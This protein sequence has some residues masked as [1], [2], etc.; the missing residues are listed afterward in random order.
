MIQDILPL[1]Q[2]DIK[3]LISELEKFKSNKELWTT[4]GDVKNSPGNLA[5]HLIGN[6]NHFI[7]A[8]LGKTDYIRNRPAEFKSKD[9]PSSEIIAQ[10]KQ[11]SKMLKKVLTE[12]PPKK[13]K[14]NFPNSP[15]DKK[16]IQWVLLQLYGHFSY[17]LGQINYYRRK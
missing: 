3:R 6:L 12:I 1:F 15:F 5:L 4:S 9:I 14:S 13:L 17:H 7:G 11:T 8:C 16:S 2:R 10:L